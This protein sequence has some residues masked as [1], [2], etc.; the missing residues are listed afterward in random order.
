M[1]NFEIEDSEDDLQSLYEEIL[2][3]NP[4]KN[5][6]QFI[7]MA[8]GLQLTMIKH[9]WFPT[10]KLI[11][12]ARKV[13]AVQSKAIQ[14][15]GGS[16]LRFDGGAKAVKFQGDKMTVDLNGDGTFDKVMVY[17]FGSTELSEK[18]KG[19]VTDTRKGKNKLVKAW[20]NGRNEAKADNPQRS[21]K[22]N[23][24][25]TLLDL[26]LN[27]KSMSNNDIQK[28]ST[29]ISAK[30]AKSDSSSSKSIFD[31]MKDI[32]DNA[33]KRGSPW[34]DFLSPKEVGWMMKTMK[35]LS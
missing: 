25:K 26:I 21:E 34:E 11:N 33:A 9:D 14:F 18:Y 24:F 13:T 5:L 32:R 23:N 31:M 10:G 8:K 16:W 29:T 20:S 1:N 2:T 22:V 7:K 15:E 3:E 12:V 35:A 17:K 30:T 4:P 27:E 6:A 28:M 19:G